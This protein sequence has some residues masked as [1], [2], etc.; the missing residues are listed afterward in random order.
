MQNTSSKEFL[1]NHLYADKPNIYI[2][3]LVFQL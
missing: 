3:S 2:S 1:E